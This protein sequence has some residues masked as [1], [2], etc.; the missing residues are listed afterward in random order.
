MSNKDQQ[1]EEKSSPK[2]PSKEEVPQMGKKEPEASP[3]VIKIKADPKIPLTSFVGK[4]LYTLQKGSGQV[5]I[6][7]CGKACQRVIDV[8]KI[9]K[10]KIGWLHEVTTHSLITPPNAKIGSTMTVCALEITL[11][12]HPLD[13][14]LPGYKEPQPPK[15]KNINN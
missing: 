7:G 10:N 5:T 13:K 15:G 14:T 12:K 1:P 11:S 9:L 8:S 2:E 4:A 6:L 3:R